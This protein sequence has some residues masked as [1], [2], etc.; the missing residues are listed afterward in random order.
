LFGNWL[1]PLFSKDGMP[2]WALVNLIL[3][4]IGA[5]YAIM[6]II[7]VR[8]R[9]RDEAELGLA[10][11]TEEGKKRRSVLL[12][13]MSVMAISS[14]I[15]FILTQ[16]MRLQVVFLDRWTIFNALILYAE[17]I[18]A[19]LAFGKMEKGEELI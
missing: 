4:I 19:K 2:A 9:K 12:I 17:I 10:N 15:L 7:R 14:I 11:D 1:I 13:V 3:C 5:L 16:D 18:I 6:T 8:R